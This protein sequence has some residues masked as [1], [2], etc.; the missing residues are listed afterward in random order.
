MISIYSVM[1][2]VFFQTLSVWVC[3]QLLLDAA[4]S[5]EGAAVRN[6][7]E[8]C[9]D[10]PLQLASAAGVYKSYIITLEHLCVL[11]QQSC[12]AQCIIDTP[13]AHTHTVYCTV[14]NQ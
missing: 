9:A 3:L 5:V 13:S 7:Q 11:C 1:T 14:T 12:F 8:S 4:A 6:G 10:T 2:F